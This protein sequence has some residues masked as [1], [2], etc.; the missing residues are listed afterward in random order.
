MKRNQAD[1]SVLC[2][3]GISEAIDVL[4]VVSFWGSESFTVVLTLFFF[5]ININFFDETRILS[6]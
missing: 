2:T 1:P 3:R 5:T 6:P 4:I